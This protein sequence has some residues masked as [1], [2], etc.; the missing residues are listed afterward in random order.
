VEER[1]FQARVWE[2]GE[3]RLQPLQPSR[4]KPG[5]NPD[6]DARLDAGQKAGS[7]TVLLAHLPDMSIL[8][9]HQIVRRL[10]TR[11]PRQLLFEVGGD[12]LAVEASI[13][14]E[15]LVGS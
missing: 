3:L 13:L 7:S 12:Q 11:F 14:D 15:D 2:Q 6:F 5:L 1:D 10:A 4:T 9:F 8:E